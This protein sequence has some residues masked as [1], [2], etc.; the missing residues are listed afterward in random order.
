VTAILLLAGTQ[1]ASLSAGVVSPAP[2][3]KIP[4]AA[5]DSL[6][7][8]IAA[9]DDT[10]VVRNGDT[11]DVHRATGP[12]A[13]DREAEIS[14]PSEAS[15]WFGWSIDVDG[16]RI[17]VGDPVTDGSRG[18]VFVYERSVGEGWVHTQT[19]HPDDTEYARFGETVVAEDDHIAVAA[20][21]DG[22]GPA[23]YRGVVYVF[24]SSGDRL[25]L[26]AKLSA[27]DST[28]ED[29]G[30]DAGNVVF[31]SSHDVY[32]AE[33]LGS[34]GW[35]QPQTIPAPD[36]FYISS[37][38]VEEQTMVVDTV[39]QACDTFPGASGEMAFYQSTEDGWQI[40]ERRQHD[41]PMALHGAEALVGAPFTPELHERGLDGDWERQQHLAPFA[42]GPSELTDSHA[43]ILD[44]A[45]NATYSFALDPVPQP[46]PDPSTG[47]DAP[48][49]T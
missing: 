25:S 3:D 24:D 22:T 14:L 2:T 44:E 13:W 17:A 7:D 26:E 5:P 42:W 48:E 40:D 46:P 29:L 21:D 20:P 18:A 23:T 19:L 8:P 30:M 4:A 27:E 12:H 45:D 9:E 41:Y 6:D 10:L 33:D 49:L 31:E 47:S 15:E 28:G 38:I 34:Q 37:I 32:A 11:T 16:D 39:C 35:S 1:A 36:G 43:L